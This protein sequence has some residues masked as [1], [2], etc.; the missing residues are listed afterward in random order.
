MSK[1]LNLNVVK[2]EKNV[3]VYV[4]AFTQNRTRKTKKERKSLK[5]GL[6]ETNI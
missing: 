6:T 1:F 2:I 4:K 3:Y 5:R